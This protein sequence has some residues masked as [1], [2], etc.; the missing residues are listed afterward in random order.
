MKKT[1]KAAD[2]FCGA[3]GTSTGLHFAAESLGLK[4]E[5]VAVNHWEQAVET[6]AANH[7][8]ANHHCED[9]TSLDPRKAVP[10]GKLDILV[11]S[12][13]CTHHSVARGGVPMNDQSRASAW[14]VLR[15]ATALRI[16]QILIENVP[17]FVSWGPIGSN[18]RPLKSRKGETFQAFIQGLVALGYRVETRVLNSAD[19]AAATSRRRLF[20][21]AVRGRRPIVWPEPTHAERPTPGLFGMRHKWRAAREIIDWNL[22]GKSIFNRKRPLVPNTLKRIEAGLRKFGGKNAEP[23]LVIL[24]NHMAGRSIDEPLPT[25]AAG[26]QHV[27]L[28]EPTPFILSHR[29]FD[30]QLVDG[31]D[32]PL[33]TITASNGND[34]AL[35]EPFIIPTNYGERAGQSPRCHSI[36]RPLPTVVTGNTHAI[37]EPFIVPQHSSNGPRSIDEPL[38]TITT[39]SRGV[40]IVEPFALHTTHH[41]ADRVHDLRSPLPTITGAN[42]GELALIDPFLVSFYGCDKGG[43]SVGEPLRTVTTKDRHGLVEPQTKFD[44]LFRML[45]PDEL[46]QGM[47]F[48]ASYRITGNREAQVKQIGNAVEVNQA[49]ALGLSMMEVA[50]A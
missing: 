16:D 50:A 45:E 49:K 23:F 25:L 35:I 18:G 38:P 22:K 10:G 29:Q 34:N 24:R 47:G 27:G 41:G 48:P 7:P 46:K 20:L 26:G 44:I 21:R 3:G 13:E 12:P 14:C 5:L 31:I 30:E 39:T 17:E 9:L 43:D 11:A 2:L 32:K 40:G 1:I 19:H 15:W 36:D 33:R 6:H 28:C 42:R 37:V 8:A 4:V